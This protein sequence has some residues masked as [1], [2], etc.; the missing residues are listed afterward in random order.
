VTKSTCC[1]CRGPRFSFQHLY[2]SSQPLLSPVIRNLTDSS[3]SVGTRHT[4]VAHTYVHTYTYIHTY[5]HTYTQIHACM[6]TYIHTCI[7][8]CMYTYMHA[9]IHTHTHTYIHIHTYVHT[10]AQIHTCMYTYIHTYGQN[11]N[12]NKKVFFK[13]QLEIPVIQNLES[14]I[15][16]K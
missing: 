14:Y 15:T 5:V 7:H 4:H 8:A 13:K 9:Y 1:F 11:A 6:Y 10:Y 16:R 12:T 2:G 3:S